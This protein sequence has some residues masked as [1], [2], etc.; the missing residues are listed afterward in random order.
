M[1]SQYKEIHV[2]YYLPK[3]TR[4]HKFKC[5]KKQENHE[6]AGG[7]RITPILY[8]MTEN[9]SLECHLPEISTI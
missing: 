1:Y 4:R 3:V 6:T 5:Q 9:R 2:K 8:N 7:R